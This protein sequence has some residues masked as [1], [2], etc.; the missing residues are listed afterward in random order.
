MPIVPV[1]LLLV[2]A[3]AL[4]AAFVLRNPLPADVKKR[5]DAAV[6]GMAARAPAAST[7]GSGWRTRLEVFKRLF[8]LGMNH[9]WGVTSTALV[10]VLVG[11]LGGGAM[12]L[13]VDAVFGLPIWV[14]LPAAAAGFWFVPSRL[15]RMEQ[16]R[17]DKAFIDRF[18]EAIDMIIRMLRAGLPM[19]AAIRTVAEESPAPINGVF[20]TLAD[21]IRIGITF[22]EALGISS[23]RIGL[24]DYR[25][26]AAA[27]A[28]QRTT[29]GNLIATLEILVD[30]IRRRRSVRLKAK[31]ATAEERISA[32]VLAGMPFLVFGALL[33]VSPTYLKPLFEDP[34]GNVILVVGVCMLLLAFLTMRFLMR[35]ATRM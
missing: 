35:R 7:E 31:A 33:V 20:T 3:A 30:I 28:L 1:I 32:Y 25:F 12:W 8:T 24:P 17:A 4:V 18:P 5:V 29:G 27:A 26:F 11:L 21:Q 2:M 22:D 14:A 23:E 9:D 16:E 10:L 34:R 15:A 6:K 19:S 13:L